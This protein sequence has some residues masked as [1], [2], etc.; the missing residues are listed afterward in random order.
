MDPETEVVV[1]DTPAPEPHVEESD[2]APLAKTIHEKFEKVAAQEGDNAEVTDPEGEEPAE[3]V[4][5]AEPEKEAVAPEPFTAEQLRDPKFFDR[6]DADGWSRLEK[7]HP[8]LHEMGKAVASARGRAFQELQQIKKAPPAVEADAPKPVSKITPEMRA[9]WQK[10]QSLDEDEAIDGSLEYNRL[11][12]EANRSP[13]E[14]VNLD[15]REALGKAVSEMPELAK[16]PMADL[17][18]FVESQPSLMRRIAHATKLSNRAERVEAVALVMLDAA[19]GYNEKLKTDQAA[20]DAAAKVEADRKAATQKRLRSNQDNV[21]TQVADSGN[22]KAKRHDP[23][24]DEAMM[25]TIA[26]KVAKARQAT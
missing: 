10:S 19:D 16:I 8:A 15:L 2:D 17:D 3:P 22:G 5:T 6:L 7:L 24:S 4:A 14:V 25:Q 23:N 21:S 13:E 11:V 26:A 9:A 12:A 20:L 18:T 1:A